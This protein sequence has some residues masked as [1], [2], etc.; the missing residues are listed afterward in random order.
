LRLKYEIQLSN[1]AIGYITGPSYIARLDR[2]D[3]YFNLSTSVIFFMVNRFLAMA[4][5]LF[6]KGISCHNLGL[7]S[8]FSSPPIPKE[9]DILRN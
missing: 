9:C 6:H 2:L 3:S 8:V 4:S 1:R 7:T 5:S